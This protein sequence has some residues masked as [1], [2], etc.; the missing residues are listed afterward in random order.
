[1][2]R[3]LRL[4]DCPNEAEHAVMPTNY[5]AIASWMH[6]KSRS[7]VQCRCSGCGRFLIWLPRTDVRR[8]TG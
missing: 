2:T 1:M 3:H 5:A 4:V 6:I 7:H 8:V